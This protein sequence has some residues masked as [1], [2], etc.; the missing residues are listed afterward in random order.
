MREGE[1]IKKTETKKQREGGT[2]GEKRERK[3]VWGQRERQ[4]WEI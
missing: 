4:K 3:C 1:K 2:D